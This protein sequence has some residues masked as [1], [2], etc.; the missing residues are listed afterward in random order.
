MAEQ[1][2]YDVVVVG[3]GAVGENAADRA[4]RSGLSVAIVESELV[5]G[6]CSYWACMPSKALLRPGAALAAAQDVPG[7][8]AAVTGTLDVAAVLARRTQFTHDWDDSSQVA[9]LESAGIELIRGAARFT[10]PRALEVATADGPVTVIARDAVVV[11]T[12]SE[13]TIPPIP[14]LDTAAPWTSREVTSAETIPESLVSIGGGVVGVEMAT[15]YTDLGCAVTLVVRGERVLSAAEP[16]AGDALGQALRDLG[17]DVR[18]STGVTSVERTADGV[19]VQLDPGGQVR[20]AEVLVATGRHPRTG[21]LGLETIGLEPGRAVPVDEHLEVTE[22]AGGWLFAVGDVTGRTATTHQGKYDA[23]IAGDVIAA[24]F[25]PEGTARVDD[26]S[27]FSRW[28]AD[29]DGIADTQVV[30][31]RPEVAW[32]GRTEAAARAD[33]IAVRCLDVELA[34]AAGASVRGDSVSGRVRLVVDEHRQVVVGATFVG[35]EVADL[36]H[37]ATIAVVGEVPLS[38]LWHAVPAYPTV[39]E[40]WLRLLESAGL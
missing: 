29:A 35:P 32:V 1:R 34:S 17:V 13:A 2:T 3:A 27:R 9:W 16:F 7:A 38:R 33:G 21:D 40:V 37:A 26:D 14:G 12:G 30:F 24:R 23:R 18:V 39:S 8:A 36:L 15:A 25:G 11:A 31:T 22:V 5:G 4:G 20:A 10:G 28:R 19:V 6:E